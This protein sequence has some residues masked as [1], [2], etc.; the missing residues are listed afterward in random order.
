MAIE[1]VTHRFETEDGTVFRVMKIKAKD[2]DSLPKEYLFE[3][4]CIWYSIGA[5]GSKSLL[6]SNGYRAGG[7]VTNNLPI[8]FVGGMY[9]KT[10]FNSRLDFIRKCGNRLKNVQQEIVAVEEKF[11]I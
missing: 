10:D 9:K 7:R 6:M 3:G 11:I 5:S 2:R 4:P 1:I 8:L